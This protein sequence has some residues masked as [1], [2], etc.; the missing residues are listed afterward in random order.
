M[1]DGLLPRLLAL[2]DD[3]RSRQQGVLAGDEQYQ[4]YVNPIELLE[5]GNDDLDELGS[6]EIQRAKRRLLQEIELEDGKIS[7][8]DSLVME[9]SRALALCDLIASDKTAL[10]HHVRVFRDKRLCDFLSRGA[11]EHFLV[12]PHD[13]ERAAQEALEDD[14]DGFGGWLSPMFAAQYDLVLAK[15]IE[16][17]DIRVVESLLDGRRWVQPQH[18][19]ACFVQAKRI[20]ERLIEAI[21]GLPKRAEKERLGAPQVTSALAHGHV[22]KLLEMLPVHF[23][24]ELGK[25]VDII[26]KIAIEAFNSHDDVHLALQVLET[27]RVLAMKSPQLRHQFDEDW[28]ALQEQRKKEDEQSAKLIFSKQPLEITKSGVCFGERR[29]AADDVSSLRWGALLNAG[30]K[31]GMV[32]YKMV[33]ASA[34]GSTIDIKWQAEKSKEQDELFGQLTYAALLHLMPP[35]I[36][37]LKAKTE[38]GDRVRIGDAVATRNGLEVTAKGWIMSRTRLIAWANVESQ[39]R[40]GMVIVSDKS[41]PK[42]TVAIPMRDV[43]NAVTLHFMTVLQGVDQ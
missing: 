42:V 15:A 25:T 26:R 12:T 10:R 6:K 4:H 41:L 22:G 27:A 32:E 28:D 23:S 34:S 16:Q 29:I 2:S 19:E 13:E 43:D 30:G 14:D 7:W 20:V 40:Q 38:R 31:A 1:L 17:Q 5:L 8:V 39:L 18:E 3:V 24:G 9:R 36:Q 35:C 11:V 33:I 37:A 21:E